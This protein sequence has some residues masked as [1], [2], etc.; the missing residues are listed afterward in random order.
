MTGLNEQERIQKSKDNPPNYESKP[1]IRP[2]RGEKVPAML[3]P[4]FMPNLRGWVAPQS[5]K[6]I[7]VVSDPKG[8]QK[9]V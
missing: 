1:R 7:R 6:N 9:N 3:F 5:L 4:N 2:R 8:D